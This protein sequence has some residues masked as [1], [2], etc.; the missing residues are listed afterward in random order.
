MSSTSEP[1]AAARICDNCG[2][3]LSGAYCQDCGA[4]D[5]ASRDLSFRGFLAEVAEEFTSLEHSKLL[6]TLKALLFRPGMLTREYFTARRVRY[7]K[8]VTL[9]LTI[10]A[11]NFFTYSVGNSVS[12]FDV[13]KSAAAS[14][15]VLR[16]N[17]ID[18]RDSLLAQIERGAARQKVTVGVL[19]ERI[20]DRWARNVSLLQI[21]LIGFFA[22]VLQLAYF[23]RRRFAV[24]HW[25]F[26]THFISFEAL[27]VV[28]MWPLYYFSGIHFSGKTAFTALVSNSAAL[29]YLFVAIRTFYGDSLKQALVR[30]PLLYLGYFIVFALT[31]QAALA[32]ALHSILSS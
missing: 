6:R 1:S 3:R 27:F 25:I 7:I 23:R 24:E 14:D 12:L 26:S 31:F 32:L 4:P 13:G 22:G 11:L 28:L 2:R 29:I 17:G 9:C 5:V 20:N 15:A 30:A 10:L 18:T 19:E 21:P 16:A 8:P